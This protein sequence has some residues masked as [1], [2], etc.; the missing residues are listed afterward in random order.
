MAHYLFRNTW[1]TVWSWIF[2]LQIHI[3]LSACILFFNEF[4]EQELF[5]SSESDFHICG[6]KTLVNCSNTFP[7]GLSN[8]KHFVRFWWDKAQNI[9]LNDSGSRS[10]KYLYIKIEPFNWRIS[11]SFKIF[12]VPKS[13]IVC[14]LKLEFQTALIA[15]FFLDFFIL[16][17]TPTCYSEFHVTF[18]SVL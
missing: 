4:K 2:K 9:L 7:I 5:I 10:L 3:C 1:I 15:F 13:R 18:L 12:S 6:R 11:Y 16:R 8:L 17:S 14:A